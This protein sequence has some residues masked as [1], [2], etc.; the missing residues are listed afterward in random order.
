MQYGYSRDL[1]VP[2][3]R[4][5]QDMPLTLRF[6]ASRRIL[7]EFDIDGYISHIPDDG[8]TV[9]SM[10]DLQFGIQ[11]VLRHE[12][13]RGPGIAVSYFFKAPTS[14]IA[15]KDSGPGGSIIAF[16]F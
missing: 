2:G 16:C 10:G 1:A 13:D 6:A 12:N 9:S 8:M 4:A 14:K 3:L 15:P 5:V 7:L 11:S